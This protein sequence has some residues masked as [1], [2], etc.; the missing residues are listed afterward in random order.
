[1]GSTEDRRRTGGLASSL[2]T[3]GGNAA[4]L[5]WADAEP[6]RRPRSRKGELLHVLWLR[7]EPCWWMGPLDREMCRNKNCF[8]LLVRL[9]A[10]SPSREI[11]LVFATKYTYLK[12]LSHV[13]TSFLVLPFWC[14]VAAARSGHHGR[15]FAVPL[16]VSC[17]SAA[18]PVRT[19]EACYSSRSVAR[20]TIFGAEPGQRSWALSDILSVRG[21]RCSAGLGCR[22]DVFL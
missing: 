6:P 5:R 13:P 21:A 14:E 12:I 4:L 11:K 20:G 17:R 1:M 16:L 3:A 10:L 15:P 19:G 8:V 7:M 22:S 9:Q 2:Q 18:Q